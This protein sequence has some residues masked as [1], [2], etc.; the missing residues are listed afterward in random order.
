MK[1]VIIIALAFVLLIP[2]FTLVDAQ[3]TIG[4]TI[5]LD[6]S[7]S[8]ITTGSTVSFS[9]QLLDENGV[10]IYGMMI[11]VLANSDTG[12]GHGKSAITD[13]SGRYTVE[14]DNFR[15][16]DVGNYTV[17]A[18]FEGDSL[19]KYHGCMHQCMSIIR[20]NL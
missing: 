3:S 20:V 5:T 9:G 8:Y 6:P 19:Y 17:F 11:M 1:P 2:F 13:S 16:N 14:L 12:R 7:D 4:T 18:E 15:D 10:P